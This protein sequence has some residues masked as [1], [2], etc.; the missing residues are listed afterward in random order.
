MSNATIYY[1]LI[2]NNITKKEIGNFVDNSDNLNNINDFNNIVSHAKDLLYKIEN[3]NKNKKNKMNL[4]NHNIY[5]IVTNSD[6]FYLAAVRKNSLYCKQEN[7]IFELIEDIDHQGI[8]KLVDKNGELTNVGRQ[9]LKFSIE[10]YQESNKNK[11]SNTKEALI[12]NDILTQP[13]SK[14][15]I[16]NENIKEIRSDMKMSVQN[17]ITNVNEMQDLDNKSS[18]IKDS[19]YKFI[20][21]SAN[22]ERKLKWQNL[23]FKLILGCIGISF[24]S[25]VIYFIFK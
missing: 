13:P 6:T 7:L 17:I 5:Y 22:L 15:S 9:N 2:A 19:S 21:E 4:E 10:K 14:I 1:F 24:L 16:L 12:D 25:I 3:T 20:Q 8:K 11:L 18:R 23:K